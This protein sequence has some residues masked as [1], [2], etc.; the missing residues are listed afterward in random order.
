M[1]QWWNNLTWQVLG[2]TSFVTTAVG[3]L[4][5]LAFDLYLYREYGNEG[6]ITDYCRANPWLAWVLL[7][8]IQ[9]GVIG[10][11]VHFMAQVKLDPDVHRPG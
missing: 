4:L 10:L 6:T 5:V 7:T 11:A 1:I 3:I 8:I 2:L 9:F